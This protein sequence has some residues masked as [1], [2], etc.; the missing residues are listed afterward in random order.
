MNELTI[1]DPNDAAEY[2]EFPSKSELL[3]FLEVHMW[4]AF[5]AE[6]DRLEVMDCWFSG[7]QPHLNPPQGATPE[8]RALLELSKTPWLGLVVTSLAQAMYVD[9]YQSP[10]SDKDTLKPVWDTWLANGMQKH[11]VAIHR[12]ALGYG[13]SYV[14]VTPGVTPSGKS[15]A[16]IRGVSPKECLCL[17]DDPAVDDFPRLALQVKW[18][19]R[20]GQLTGG[21][22]LFLFDSTTMWTIRRD[23]DK[24]FEVVK[25]QPHG[26]QVVPFV[27]YTNMLDLDG[28]APGEIDLNVKVASRIDK[29]VYDRLVAQHFGSW[30]QRWI[31]GLTD[32]ATSQEDGAR[33]KLKLAQDQIAVFEDTEVKI[34]DWDATPLDGY[35]AAKEEDVDDLAS[36]SQLPAHVLRGSRLSNMA[37]DAL[38]AA[39]HPLTQKV[40]ERQVSFGASH[41]AVL[42]LAAALDGHG[43][44]AEDFSAHVTWQDMQIRSLAQAADALGKMATLL[45]VPKQAL[46]RLIPGITQL[47]V[48]H[49]EQIA[50]DDEDPMNKKWAEEMA[51]KVPAK[52]NFGGNPSGSK[53][54]AQSD[55]SVA[56]GGVD[57]P[58]G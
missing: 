5:E 19:R 10:E 58:V 29:T 55:A 3:D 37:A 53:S 22:T 43:D 1:D 4:P 54:P 16:Y 9:G 39:S 38:A 34:G 46:W 20:A 48:E 7:D 50:L 31:V 52:V 32:F 15:Q 49:W 47:D 14:R 41:E 26:S 51:S 21:A 27:R 2:G 12:A 11:Q 23:Q 18:D 17:Y 56:G 8:L 6:R 28:N 45:G 36:V 42:R 24:G 25:S 57:R 33:K 44:V 13:Y 35:L 30:K 40:Y